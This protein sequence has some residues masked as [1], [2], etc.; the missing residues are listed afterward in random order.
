M[1]DV[2][3]G[4]TEDVEETDANIVEGKPEDESKEK[5]AVADI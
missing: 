4:P 5:T 2:L 1:F 3:Q